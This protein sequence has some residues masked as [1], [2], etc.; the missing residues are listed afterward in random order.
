MGAVTTSAAAAPTLSCGLT[1]LPEVAPPIASIA[2][3]HPACRKHVQSIVQNRIVFIMLGEQCLFV[4]CREVISG[5]VLGRDGGRI[6]LILQGFSLPTCVYQAGSAGGFPG[7]LAWRIYRAMDRW[8]GGRNV[9][10][11]PAGWGGRGFSIRSSVL[12]SSIFTEPYTPPR[13]SRGFRGR[14]GPGR[15]CGRRIFCRTGG[16]RRWWCCGTPLWPGAIRSPW[17]R[18]RG[19]AV[20]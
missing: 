19:R 8:T 4:A 7:E 16:R 15:G 17:C 20:R 13:R 12:P 5:R 18:R 6:S 9:E 3:K 2:E 1:F 14:W 11:P 10:A